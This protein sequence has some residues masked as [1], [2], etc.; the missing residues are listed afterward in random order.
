MQPCSL[1]LLQQPLLLQILHNLPHTILHT[2]EITPN[3]NLG[4]LRRLVRR[5]NARELWNLALPRLLV[6]A[7]RI[8]R[9][10]NFERDVDEDLDEGEGLVGARG[11]GV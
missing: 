10:G 3:S 4:I 5:T 8:A 7:L 1:L 2:L 11:Y 9:L 6:Q